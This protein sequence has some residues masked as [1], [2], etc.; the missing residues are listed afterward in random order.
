MTCTK[1]STDASAF[2]FDP[3]NFKKTN[4]ACDRNPNNPYRYIDGR[5]VTY[6]GGYPYC[7]LNSGRTYII[8]AQGH[9]D[10]QF[11]CTVPRCHAKQDVCN[12][13]FN[14]NANN[15]NGEQVRLDY[16]TNDPNLTTPGSCFLSGTGNG[17]WQCIDLANTG[18]YNDDERNVS[19]YNR[20][21]AHSVTISNFQIQRVYVMGSTECDANGYCND[22]NTC[23]DPNQ[24][25]YI[26]KSG[27]NT[28]NS[29]DFFGRLDYPCNLQEHEIDGIYFCGSRS[30]SFYQNPELHN[31][32][33]P[34]NGG[35]FQW[36]ID[37]TS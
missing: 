12:L 10:I 22:T 34:K 15:P 20:S 36:N 13:L 11:T 19:I 3:V 30:Y 9:V 5:G 16:Y 28:D 4:Y 17:G 24:P 21:Q 26:V 25:R 2:Q 37:W 1:V 23:N 29:G 14:A 8:P 33:L 7:G 6:W 31:Q 27:S 32:T 18:R 35:C